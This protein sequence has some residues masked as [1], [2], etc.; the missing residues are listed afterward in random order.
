[1]TLQRFI[2]GLIGPAILQV[3]NEGKRTTRKIMLIEG[4]RPRFENPLKVLAWNIMRNYNSAQ[5]RDSLE[6]FKDEHDP[7]VFM[8]QEVPVY[9]SKPWWEIKGI[10]ELFRGYNLFYAPSHHVK[11]QNRVMNFQMSG[12]LI[13]CRY[14]FEVAHAILLPTV[15]GVR[16]G[17]MER[18]TGYVKLKA[19]GKRIGL[20]NVHLENACRPKGRRQQALSVINNLEKD[21]VQIV[22]G[23][24]NT[25]FGKF[26]TCLGE[27]ENAGFIHLLKETEGFMQLDHIFVKGVEGEVREL[28]QKG[29]D[30]EAILASFAV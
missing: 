6:R 29:S 13:A 10:E 26:E 21:D 22:A 14:G 23:D 15:T 2:R 12:T 20:T 3:E 1:M 17:T 7:D 9:A 27:L 19:K 16:E 4:K 24:F 25:I 11:K 28:N 18:S 8:L 30:H 5:I